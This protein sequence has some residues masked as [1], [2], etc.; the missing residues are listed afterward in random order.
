MSDSGQ[1]H[2]G[3]EEYYL[4][5]NPPDGGNY[6]RKARGCSRR[7]ARLL[8]AADISSCLDLGCGTGMLTGFLSRRGYEQVVGV[9]CNE[10]LIEVAK[11]NVEA[12][13]VVDDACRYLE[14]CGRT[15]DVIFL[16]DLLE[17]IHRDDVVELL[18]K[19]H[20]ALNGGGFAVVRTPNMNCLQAAGMFYCDWTHVTAFT[21]GTLFDVAQL[22]GFSRVEFCNQFR[23]Q[24]FKGKI[25]ACINAA[26]IPALMWLRGGKKVKVYYRNLVAQLFK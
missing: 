4:R 2:R 17:H 25:R 3:Y 10:K 13:F 12:E 19:V 7:F 22:A 18:T 21:E 5:V 26:V 24:N 9:D 14:T 1:P 16:L 15:F 6:A 8:D 20:V 23:M 11:S